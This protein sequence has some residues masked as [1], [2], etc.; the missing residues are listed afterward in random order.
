MRLPQTT[1]EQPGWLHDFFAGPDK[2]APDQQ[3]RMMLVVRL[4][5]LNVDRETGGPFAAAV[6]DAASG[7]LLAPGVNLVVGARCSVAHAE[8]VA[9]MAAQ[10]ILDTH[11]LGAPGMPHCQLVS[12]TEPC[13]MCLGAIP[14]SGVRSLVCGA[15]AEDACSIGMDEGA[16][17]ERWVAALEQ[18]GISVT[19][20]VCRDDA[21]AVLQHYARTG[22]PLYNG[23]SGPLPQP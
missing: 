13:A 8:I 18:R 10:Q 22:G 23:R 2:I 15:R 16:K 7:R 1:I 5:R 4:A 11:D 19:R 6:F 17:P 21:V 20:D 9:I 14:W 3:A 12:S